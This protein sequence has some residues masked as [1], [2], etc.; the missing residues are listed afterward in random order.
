MHSGRTLL[1]LRLRTGRTHQIRVHMAAI[2]HPLTGDPLYGAPSVEIARPA[3]HS[4]R[5]VLRHPI[6]GETVDLTSPLP[7]DMRGLIP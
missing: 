1:R 4:H 6:T 3:L 7:E 5:L 2:G